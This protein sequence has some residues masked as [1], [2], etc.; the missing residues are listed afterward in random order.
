MKKNKIVFL[1]IGL[2]VIITIFLCFL[3]PKVVEINQ[4]YQEKKRYTEI[5]K[6]AK[7][8]VEWYIGAV[9]QNVR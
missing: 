3:F 1:S 5:K 9:Y 7:Q 4:K 2:V 6:S 8:A